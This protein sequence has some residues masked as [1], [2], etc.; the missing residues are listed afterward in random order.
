MNTTLLPVVTYVQ[1]NCS[2]ICAVSIAAGMSI[3]RSVNLPSSEVESI[4]MHYA[5]FVLPT[6]SM[7]LSQ[8]NE[9]TPLDLDK[10]ASVARSA[11]MLRYSAAYPKADGSV[12][13][14]SQ[15]SFFERYLGV[16]IYLDT[17]TKEYVD[18]HADQVISIVN[19]FLVA[20]PSMLEEIS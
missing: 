17:Q 4:S 2:D 1:Q 10:A 5:E 14:P 6:V 12:I 18:T 11:Y 16:G 3:A 8:I 20:L 7:H 15:G 9:C 13:L 19:R